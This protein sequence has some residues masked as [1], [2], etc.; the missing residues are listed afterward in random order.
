MEIDEHALSRVMPPQAPRPHLK[1]LKTQPR[2]SQYL[3]TD[4]DTMHTLYDSDSFC[5]NHMLANAPEMAPREA[6]AG[7][8][9]D[10]ELLSAIPAMPRHG[11]EIIDKRS[12]KEIYLDGSWAEM[13]QQQIMAW[14]ATT[15]TQEEVEDTLEGYASLAHTPVVM[16]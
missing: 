9:S 11:F 4:P 10:R 5:V 14:Q 12:G 13:F 16:H 1:S 7:H 15:P 8:A 3:P 2:A 6:D